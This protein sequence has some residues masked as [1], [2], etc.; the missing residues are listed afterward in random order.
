MRVA[1]VG[2]DLWSKW[3]MAHDQTSALTTRAAGAE[4]LTEIL[5][6]LNHEIL[7]GTA[8]FG[9]EPM[10]QSDIER[11]FAQ[12]LPLAKA[13]NPHG[14][15]ALAHPWVVGLLDGRVAGFARASSWKSRGAYR[16]TCE[17]GVY[18]R[19]ELHGR[20]IGKQIYRVLI[21]K[22]KETGFKTLLGGIA[23][24]N[25]A[26]IRLHEALGFRYVGTLPSV[27]WKFGEWRDVA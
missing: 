19:Q 4:D 25:P 9:L 22:L 13:E 2:A 27:G 6:I 17:V 20:G 5:E 10:K 26:S 18:V 23:L 11:E 15:K 24:P 12:S 1:D 8:H 14:G 7:T 16:N 3:T 21:A